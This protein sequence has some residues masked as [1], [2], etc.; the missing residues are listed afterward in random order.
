MVD[1][2][3]NPQPDGNVLA[4]Q[5][6]TGGNLYVGGSIGGHSRNGIAKITTSGAG[7][8]DVSWDPDAAAASPYW[9]VSV[10]AL[11]LNSAGNIYAG[12]SFASSGRQARN[13]VAKLSTSGSGDADANW[14][15]APDNNVTALAVGGSG[16][17]YLGGP[18]AHIGGQARSGLAKIAAAGV[19][20][21]DVTWDPHPI[22][23]YN[24]AV[25]AL[26]AD[27]S[28]NVFVAGAWDPSPEYAPIFALAL[29]GSG[30]VFVTG[31]ISNIGG[32]A[33]HGL[34]KLSAAG[35]GTADA[36]WNPD[37]LWNAGVNSIVNAVAVD[38]AGNAR[39]AHQHVLR[40]DAERHRG[41]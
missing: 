31:A 7:S 8:A 17:I 35:T 40:N 12:G 38:A 6:D 32:Q 41:A 11:A 18:F 4:L 20:A 1:A 37:P 29:D 23:H 10:Q 30:G 2:T 26:A 28:G 3:W 9:T 33:R 39:R 34:A 5:I 27:A 15:P 13:G 21:V 24:P 25:S 14:N 22:S 36:T 19:G 16:D